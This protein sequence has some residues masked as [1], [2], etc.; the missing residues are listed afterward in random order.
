ME[1]K[2]YYV[3]CEE[4]ASQYEAYDLT[5]QTIVCLLYT[6]K[7]YSLLDGKTWSNVKGKELKRTAKSGKRSEYVCLLY[8]SRCV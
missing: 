6:S 5:S 1:K 4:G 3:E 7:S 2:N 8:T